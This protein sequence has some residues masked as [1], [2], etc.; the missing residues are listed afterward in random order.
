ML[1]TRFEQLPEEWQTRTLLFE[2]AWAQRLSR[3][4]ISRKEAIGW[5]SS[6]FEDIFGVSRH[7]GDEQDFV[8]YEVSCS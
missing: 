7:S 1:R 6:N 8:A 5:I 3:G 2:A 4:E